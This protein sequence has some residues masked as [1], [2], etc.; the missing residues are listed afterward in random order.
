MAFWRHEYTIKRSDSSM[1]IA[2]N[3]LR[4][5]ALYV[6]YLG[7]YRYKLADGMEAVPLWAMLPAQPAR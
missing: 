4:L 6:L 2:M 3:D 1:R 7:L 5:D